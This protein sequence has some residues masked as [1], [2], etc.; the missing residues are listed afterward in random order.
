MGPRPFKPIDFIEKLIEASGISEPGLYR[1]QP[2]PPRSCKRVSHT[3]ARAIFSHTSYGIVRV[4]TIRT[5][6]NSQVFYPPSTQNHFL[7]SVKL[8]TTSGVKPFD[9]ASSRLLQGIACE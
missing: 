2:I 4:A 8:L 9:A 1:S 3:G 5:A 7:P 6:K